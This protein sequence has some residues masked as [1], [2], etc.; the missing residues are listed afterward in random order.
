MRSSAVRPFLCSATGRPHL[1]ECRFGVLR[2]LR[3]CWEMK[4]FDVAASSGRLPVSKRLERLSLGWLNHAIADELA[5]E[6]GEAFSVVAHYRPI[7]KPNRAIE[8]QEMGKAT[9]N[10]NPMNVAAIKV[11]RDGGLASLLKLQECERGVRRPAAH[12]PNTIDARLDHE[13]LQ[14]RQ[15]FG[16]AFVIGDQF[17]IQRGMN[18][19]LLE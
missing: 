9:P 12:C 11:L 5:A 14:A 18:Q 1:F 8:L 6:R 4:L 2:C 7:A 10:R 16:V 19:S 13:L 17:P 15:P 3:D